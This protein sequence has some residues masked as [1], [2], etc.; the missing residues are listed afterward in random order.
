V[1]AAAH[2]LDIHWWGSFIGWDEP[3]PPELPASF[4]IGIW[5]DVP[6]PPENFSHPG[7]L[8]WE[9]YC[10]TYTWDFVGWDF[11]PRPDP[12]TGFQ[13]P[14]EATFYFQQ[15]LDVDDWFWQD[16]GDNIYWI[17]IAAVYPQPDQVL[18]PFGWKTRPRDLESHAPDDAVRIFDPTDPVMGSIYNAGQPIFWPNE[19]DSWDMAFVL[20]TREDILDFGDA[21]DALAAPIYPTL[22]ANNG[23]RH[24]IAGPWLGDANDVPD[25]EPDGQ[26]DPNAL[27]DDNDGN[28]DE[29]GVQIP[30]LVPGQTANIS[31]EV[32][33]GGGNLDAWIDFNQ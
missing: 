6:S 7:K 5:T 21:P 20:T 12:T 32:N 3:G 10:D 13:K 25:S 33:G 28:D 2:A 16:T 15:D 27:G 18:Y 14:P 26:P 22:L 30:A 1:V 17:T 23:A 19:T 31:V 11:D 4:H 29:D 8:I 24:V 9:N